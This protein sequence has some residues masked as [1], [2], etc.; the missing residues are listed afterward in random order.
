[1]MALA[2]TIIKLCLL[3]FYFPFAYMLL[4]ELFDW[5]FDCVWRRL[6]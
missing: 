4:N 6:A 2:P 5:L 3:A 1:M